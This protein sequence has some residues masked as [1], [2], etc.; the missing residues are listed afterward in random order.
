MLQWLMRGLLPLVSSIQSKGP[1]K[2]KLPEYERHVTPG[3]FDPDDSMPACPLP[4]EILDELPKL[5]GVAA[6]HLAQGKTSA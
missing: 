2:P 4:G 3:N 5:A 1:K 6:R